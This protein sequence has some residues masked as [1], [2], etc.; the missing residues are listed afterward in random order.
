MK[1]LEQLNYKQLHNKYKNERKKLGKWLTNDRRVSINKIQRLCCK[2]LKIQKYLDNPQ[3]IRVCETLS[4]Y[5][6]V[7]SL[8]QL[9]TLADTYIF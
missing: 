1:K 3:T 9:R 5:V 6:A 2:V 7:L 8:E 4:Y